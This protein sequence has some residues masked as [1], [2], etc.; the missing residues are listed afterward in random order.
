MEYYRNLPHF[1]PLESVFFITIRLAG[2][3]PVATV[4][5]LKE[6]QELALKRLSQQPDEF[7]NQKKRYFARFDEFLDDPQNGPY[8]LAE[9]EIANVIIEA[10][11]FR[12]KLDYILIAYCLMSNHI[13]FVID[14]RE[15]K[16]MDK[17]LFRVLQSFKR[18]TAQKANLLLNRTGAFWHAE[19]YDRIVRD[20]V[21]L[22]KII[23]YVLQNPVKAGLCDEWMNWAHSYVNEEY[24]V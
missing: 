21:E 1:H 10:L 13:H 7:V 20:S 16:D 12:N 18:Y 4:E 8:W 22:K 17:P 24:L 5:M 11:Q 2:S 19:S 15:A 14:T 23:W 9:A 6:E 3:L